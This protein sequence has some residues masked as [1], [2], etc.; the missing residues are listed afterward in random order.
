MSSMHLGHNSTLWSFTLNSSL[1]ASTRLAKLLQVT[2]NCLYSVCTERLLVFLALYRVQ[3]WHLDF[4]CLSEMIVL[5]LNEACLPLQGGSVSSWSKDCVLH[6]PCLPLCL[7]FAYQ[8]TK[9]LI[10]WGWNWE[11]RFHP[12][13]IR[14]SPL[15]LT[16]TKDS[17]ES[18][19]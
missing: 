8:R 10:G 3:A 15:P 6:N 19:F 1:I 11:K 5:N 9:Q 4:T 12:V 13:P 14:Q 7:L 16:Q 2:Y 18:S 17:A